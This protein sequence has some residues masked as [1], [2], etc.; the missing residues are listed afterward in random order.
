MSNRCRLWTAICHASSKW[1]GY[2]GLRAHNPLTSPITQRSR[3]TYNCGVKQ[4]PHWMYWKLICVVVLCCTAVQSQQ[5]TLKLRKLSY[6]KFPYEMT[7]GDPAT[8]KYGMFENAAYKAAYH[9]RD[10][11]LYV[12]S[13]RK[14]SRLLHV[15]DMNHPDKPTILLSQEIGTPWDAYISNV[16]VCTD[17]VAVT[18]INHVPAESGH[19][20]YY[21]PYNRATQKLV[22]YGRNIVGHSPSDLAFTS[23]CQRLVVVNEGVPGLNGPADSASS[24]FV[25]P[26]PS[27]FII[28]KRNIGYPTSQQVGFIQFDAREME[29]VRRGVRYTFR[30]LHELGIVNTFSQDLEPKAVT[31]SN[32]DKYAFVSLQENNAIARVSLD[33]GSIDLFPL[34][35]K[36][37]TSYDMDPSDY[38]FASLLKRYRVYSMYQPGDLA[39]GVVNGKGFLIS[40]DTG[41]MKQLS[42]SGINYTDGVRCKTALTDGDIDRY[43]METT[44]VSQLDDDMELGRVFMSKQDGRDLYGEIKN[45]HLFGGRGISLWDPVN[46]N[47]VFDTGD[48][49]ERK[50][51]MAY[52]TTFNGDCSDPNKSPTSEKDQRSDDMGP[53]PTS[54]A[55]GTYNTSSVLVVGTRTGRI[56]LYTMRGIDAIFQTIHRE[57]DVNEP[58]ATLYNK[59]TAGDA[60]IS[61]IGYIEAADSATR[62]PLIYVIGQASGSLSIY[63]VYT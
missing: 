25:D 6:T 35:V 37:W 26:D 36:N 32:D 58:W 49:L 61:D 54:L 4:P 12:A 17:T 13:N 48:E 43:V 15:L 55:T 40:A 53:E 21:S 63:E 10:R 16:A 44:L 7:N 24:V 39:F 11:I 9:E 28:D 47:H 50:D 46:M 30:G 41:K 29:M 62:T 59:G 52:D 27:V 19:V 33:N 1:C 56:Y 31:I 18:L 23:N 8:G 42:V 2:P 60:I 20:E 38:N 51:K 3:R 34:G 45:I 5:Q 22:K 57:G 14:N